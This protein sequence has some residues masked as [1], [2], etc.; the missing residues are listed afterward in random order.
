MPHCQTADC[1]VIECVVRCSP[2]GDLN[3]RTAEAEYAAPAPLD[4]RRPL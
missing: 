1:A 2:H 3:R 4:P